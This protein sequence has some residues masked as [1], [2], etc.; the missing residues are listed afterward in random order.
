MTIDDE[1]VLVDYTFSASYRIPSEQGD[2]V[3]Q[4]KVSDNRIELLPHQDEFR[5]IAGM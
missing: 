5:I 1:R 3:W 2:D 4:R